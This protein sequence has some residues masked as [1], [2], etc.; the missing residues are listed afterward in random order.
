MEIIN[1]MLKELNELNTITGNYDIKVINQV[2]ELPNK[3]DE[4]N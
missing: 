2:L 3:Y 4:A 1:T